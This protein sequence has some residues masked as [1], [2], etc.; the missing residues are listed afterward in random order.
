MAERKH[1]GR[2]YIGGVRIGAV[3]NEGSPVHALLQAINAHDGWIS[4][5]QWLQEAD[6][7]DR[8][9]RQA[10]AQLRY[11]L[12]VEG[13]MRGSEEFYRAIDPEV[14]IGKE[15]EKSEE[16]SAL[17][18]RL[19]KRSSDRG[20]SRNSHAANRT[21]LKPDESERDDDLDLRNELDEPEDSD[22]RERVD[23]S[24]KIRR[25]QQ[26][27]RTDL[28]NRYGDIC[29]ISGC[30]LL[31]LLEAAHIKPY[32]GKNDNDEKNGLLL[33]ADLHT[34]F[35]LNLIGIEPDT[36]TINIHPRARSAGYDQFGGEKLRCPAGKRPSKKAL[37]DRWERFNERLRS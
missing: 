31:D 28:R 15:D 35:D 17:L 5:D 29:M 3:P 23:R 9:W 37:M 4:R 18:A 14:F 36:L 6:V 22:T 11:A 26:A 24:I 16:I 2:A 12:R 32:R 20:H 21:Y 30:T 13:Q 19:H 8:P 1:L 7:A 10:I 27:F 25:G 33:R 34:L